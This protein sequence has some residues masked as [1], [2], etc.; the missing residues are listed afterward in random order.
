MG[1]VG[2]SSINYVLYED[3]V[4]AL[5]AHWMFHDYPIAEFPTKKSNF[6]KKIKDISLLKVVTPIREPVSRNISA[7]FRTLEKYCDDPKHITAKELQKIFVKKK[8]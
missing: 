8:E 6:E 7:F 1:K 5:H 3:G 2:S 4:K